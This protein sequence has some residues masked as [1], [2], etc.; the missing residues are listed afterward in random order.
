MRLSANLLVNMLENDQLAIAYQKAKEFTIS[1]NVI[2]IQ[3][4]KILHKTLK[5]YLD[6]DFHHHE[7]KIKKTTK[8]YLY[9]D[10]YDG[11]MIYEIQTAGFDKLRDKLTNFLTTYEVTIVHPIPYKKNLYKIDEKGEITGPKKSPKT[12][13]VFEVFKELYKIKPYLKNPHLKLKILLINVD[14]YRL[15]TPK[16]Y[17]HQKGYK[18]EIQIPK[19]LIAEIDLNCK[20]D[21]LKILNKAHLE[22][23]FTSKS[24]AKT[25][26]ISLAKAQVA[27]NILNYL[28]IIQKVGKKGQSYLY[29][30]KK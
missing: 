22:E 6:P 26:K 4:E 2:G 5:Y 29:Q 3:K 9:A 30:I 8:G 18:K 25:L 23:E 19:T 20:E 12:G 10:I 11:K 21:Y 17:Y 7:I 24:F 28:E 14:E 15:L 1:E 13:N 27:L 16:K